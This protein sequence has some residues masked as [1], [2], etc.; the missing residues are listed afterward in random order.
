MV[1]EGRENTLLPHVLVAAAGR[2][3]FST[4]LQLQKH[5]DWMAPPEE[6]V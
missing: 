6:Q 4:H 2:L 3:Y 5:V 1:M